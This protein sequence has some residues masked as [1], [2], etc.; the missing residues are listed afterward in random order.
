MSDRFSR[1]SFLGERSEATLRSLTIGV[2][3]LGGGGSHIVQQLAHVG[4]GRFI[5]FD[6]QRIE[7]SNLN[8]LVGATEKDIVRKELKTTIARRLIKR[9]NP[10]A[11]VHAVPKSWRHEAEKLRWCD[12]IVGCVDTYQTRSELEIQARRYLVPYLD[13][14]MDVHEQQDGGFLVAGQVILSMPGEPC[15][16]CMRFL[17]TELLEDEARRYG[18]VGGRPQVVWPNGILA[19]TAVCVLVNLFTPWYS[20]SGVVYVEY[21]G[22]RRTVRPSNRLDHL[23][24]MCEHFGPGDLGDPWFHS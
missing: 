15:M 4:V 24:S 6:P 3:G 12:L 11:I 22:N 10:T 13:L 7:D 19:S 2:V 17:R 1:Q 18:D 20:K 21:D 14:G 16:R 23:P 5:L 9:I 8:R